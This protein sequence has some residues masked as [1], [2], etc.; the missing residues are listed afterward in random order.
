MKTSYIV[1]AAMGR[2]LEEERISKSKT[3]AILR[4]IQRQI[5]PP[6]T[7]EWRI[8]MRM[9]NKATKHSVGPLMA[10]T[11]SQQ[12]TRFTRLCF[13]N[14][15]IEIVDLSTEKSSKINNFVDEKFSD[16]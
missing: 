11:S 12:S 1:T 7:T 13:R 5:S 4:R 3:G 10:I 6:L 16:K 14:N 15:D 8:N 9:A 2:L